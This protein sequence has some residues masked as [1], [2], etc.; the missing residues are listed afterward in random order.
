VRK[1]YYGY[2]EKT[3]TYGGKGERS[4]DYVYGGKI[5]IEVD[6]HGLKRDDVKSLLEKIE[7]ILEI[8]R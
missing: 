3:I 7:K 2:I 8:R 5:E 6:S 1:K 4:K